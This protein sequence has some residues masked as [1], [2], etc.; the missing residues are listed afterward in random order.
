M[1]DG[2]RSQFL[3][4][5]IEITKITENPKM[6]PLMM[7]AMGITPY[8]EVSYE[9]YPFEF[10]LPDLRDI[11]PVGLS[12]L[13][14]ILLGQATPFPKPFHLCVNR[15]DNILDDVILYINTLTR[16][17]FNIICNSI[18]DI[19]FNVPE[20]IIRLHIMQ[21]IYIL[22]LMYDERQHRE[23]INRYWSNLITEYNQP[24]DKLENKRM[25]RITSELLRKMYIGFIEHIRLPGE[26]SDIISQYCYYVS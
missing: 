19:I 22:N 18:F 10:D 2:D 25:I 15:I 13:E 5:F 20:N 11:K 21:I 7:N 1:K 4:S 26:L 16:D 3:T 12:K 8:P 23:R 14:K 17:Q 9:P 6:I 24:C